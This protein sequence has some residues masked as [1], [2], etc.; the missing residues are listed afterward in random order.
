MENAEGAL[1]DMYIEELIEIKGCC[2]PNATQGRYPFI[3]IRFYQL[4]WHYVLGRLIP[5]FFIL[6]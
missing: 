1:G 6:A 2:S 4:F 5:S 3:T